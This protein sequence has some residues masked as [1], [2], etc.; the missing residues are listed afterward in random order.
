MSLKSI[1]EAFEHA[2]GKL[3]K[4]G[5]FINSINESATAEG[6]IVVTEDPYYVIAYSDGE[7]TYYYSDRGSYNVDFRGDRY[8]DI[9]RISD[10]LDNAVIFDTEDEAEEYLSTAN[11]YL[12]Y[13]YEHIDARDS[14]YGGGFDFDFNDGSV[15]DLIDWLGSGMEVVK[16]GG[17]EP[18]VYHVTSDEVTD[19][20]K[21]PL[22]S[23][24]DLENTD[25]VFL[26]NIKIDESIKSINEKADWDKVRDILN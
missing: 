6:K 22:K 9:D 15:E 12:F 21:D 1:N 16:I 14:R 2:Y 18:K 11:K 19:K 20:Y 23:F 7:G 26:N 17:D 13:F 25:G 24:D 8:Y 5:D 4:N 10:D 3:N